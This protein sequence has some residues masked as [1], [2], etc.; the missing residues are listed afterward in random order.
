MTK[1]GCLLDVEALRRDCKKKG[2]A[3]SV[4]DP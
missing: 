3:V 2:K 4:K 1:S